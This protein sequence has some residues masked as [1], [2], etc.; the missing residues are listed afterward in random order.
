MAS[1]SHV[2]H[3]KSPPVI[4]IPRDYNAAYD[5]IERN[6]AAGRGGKV[7]FIDDA[8]RYTYGELAE[9]VNRAAN[10]LVGLGL[11]MEDRIMLC[12]LD[13]IDFPAVFL[14]AIQAGIVDEGDFPGTPGGEVTLDEIVGRVVLARY[15]DQGRTGA[16]ISVAP[17]YHWR[18]SF[19]VQ[20][21][22]P[23]QQ[24][25]RLLSAAATRHSRTSAR[26]LGILLAAWR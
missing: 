14:G 8:G 23:H 6:L 12:H 5:L 20:T 16:V 15:L 7:A 19:A 2:D 17:A 9:R 10:A 25:S 13:T 4:T 11:E 24:R 18:R 22:L 3:S 1:P 21:I 26:P